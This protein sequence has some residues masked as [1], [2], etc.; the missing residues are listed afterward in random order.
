M[1]RPIESKAEQTKR[2]AVVDHKQALLEA[3]VA[4]VPPLT[5]F[6][7]IGELIGQCQEWVRTRMITHP[8]KL[9]IRNGRYKVP[10]GYAIQFIRAW[11]K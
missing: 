10:Q 6:R 1:R 8:S 3:I 11:M 9:I 2:Q 7:E 4:Q 5:G